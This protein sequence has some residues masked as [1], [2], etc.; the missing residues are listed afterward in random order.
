MISAYECSVKGERWARVVNHSSPGKAKA[1]Y[2]RDVKESWQDILFTA[3][4]CRRIGAPV[5]P[6][7]FDRVV[8]YR[9]VSFKCGDRVL[10][11]KDHGYIVGHNSSANFDVLFDSGQTL[12]VHPASI[13]KA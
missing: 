10:V 4:R 1:E 12:N 11:G 13:Q 9:G 5:N 2:F 8:E 7:G 6:P 3:I